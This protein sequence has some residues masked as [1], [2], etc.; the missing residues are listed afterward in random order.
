MRRFLIANP[1]S[2]RVRH[3]RACPGSASGPVPA[4]S[5]QRQSGQAS[6]AITA[7][8]RARGFSAE[9]LALLFG[10]ALFQMGQNS[11]WTYVERLAVRVKISNA[12]L[13][14]VLIVSSLAA[15]LCNVSVSMHNR[16]RHCRAVRDRHV[17]NGTF[18]RPLARTALRS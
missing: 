16:L 15:I 1:T 6:D 13:G 9:A 5:A 4:V 3:W 14:H 17:V 7:A 12:A 2:K 18:C 8:P 11:M 10:W